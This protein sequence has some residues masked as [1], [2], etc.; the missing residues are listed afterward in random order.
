MLQK[1]F[2][3][4]R[5]HWLLQNSVRGFSIKFQTKWFSLIVSSI[6]CKHLVEQKYSGGAI[7]SSRASVKVDGAEQRYRQVLR[8]PDDQHQPRRRNREGLREEGAHLQRR[9]QR[10]DPPGVV[11]QHHHPVWSLT[12]F[13]PRL[14]PST[15]G[16]QTIRSYR[17]KSAIL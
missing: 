13:N 9:R 2:C 15:G 10:L 14:S 17:P 3:K 5:N 7:H 8:P 1:G 11:A 6:G 16:N 4:H 12:L